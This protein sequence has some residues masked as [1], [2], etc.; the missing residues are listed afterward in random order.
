M[1]LLSKQGVVTGLIVSAS[2][3][4]NTIDALTFSSSFDIL[5]SGSLGIGTSVTGSDKVKVLGNVNILGPLTASN[6]L[7]SLSMT[8]SRIELS[9]PITASNLNITNWNNAFISASRSLVSSSVTA[10]WDLAYSGSIVS[11]SFSGSATKT[12]FLGKRDG[13]AITASFIDSGSGASVSGSDKYI[14]MF[15]SGARSLTEG[16]ASFYFRESDNKLILSGALELRDRFSVAKGVSAFGNDV[17]FSSSS[18]F[19]GTIHQSIYFHNSDANLTIPDY[20]TIVVLNVQ[21]TA[22]RTITFNYNYDFTKPGRTL[23]IIN[24]SATPSFNWNIASTGVTFNLEST[25]GTE[26]YTSLQR[27]TQYLINIYEV[28]VSTYKGITLLK[29]V[30]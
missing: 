3:V 9:G 19:N 27:S 4:Y 21:I 2:H 24:R 28:T 8:G 20:A 1:P 15:S 10:S 7:V 5:I 29:Q 30:I 16:T 23:R 12:L 25:S 13:T 18:I 17:T 11:A 22:D 26:I 14:A 6:L